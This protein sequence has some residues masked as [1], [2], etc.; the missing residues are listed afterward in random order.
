MKYG[1]KMICQEINRGGL[2]V[3][4]HRVPPEGP[5]YDF[6]PSI[7]FVRHII[8]LSAHDEIERRKK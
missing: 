6:P 1:R 5:S 7:L 4:N 2:R 3:G 8:F